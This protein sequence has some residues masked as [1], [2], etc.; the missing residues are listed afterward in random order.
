MVCAY[1]TQTKFEY[2]HATFIPRRR[3]LKPRSH[4]TIFSRDLSYATVACNKSFR[5]NGFP[6]NFWL[7]T[8]CRAK[9]SKSRG[10]QKLLRVN[11]L[12]LVACDF[13][14]HFKI[15]PSSAFLRSNGTTKVARDFI[16]C[17]AMAGSLGKR[18]P[19]LN[20]IDC[21]DI[22]NLDYCWYQFLPETY[23]GSCS[24]GLPHS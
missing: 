23:P 14:K 2:F 21:W 11:D 7:R 6:C 22:L 8:T 16:Q 24:T 18:S 17:D 10:L 19:Y 15:V 1:A 4:D 3:N 20:G 5:V 13:C 9:F 12:S